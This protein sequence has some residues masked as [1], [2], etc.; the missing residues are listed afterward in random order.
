MEDPI[1]SKPLLLITGQ[2]GDVQLNGNKPCALAG[3]KALESEY[4]GRETI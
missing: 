3:I 2:S 1:G 4:P